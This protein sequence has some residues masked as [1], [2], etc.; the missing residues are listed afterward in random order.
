MEAEGYAVGH[1]VLGAHSVGSVHQRQRL[2]WLADN[3]NQ[4]FDGRK[5]STGITGRLEPET[6]GAINRLADSI[7]SGLE[8]QFWN[9]DN[10][11]EPG[12]KQ[13]NS[14]RSASESCCDSDWM[15]NTESDR[16]RQDGHGDNGS[17]QRE[18]RAKKSKI[19]LMVS[20]EWRDPDWL[21]CRD[22][23]YR[24]IK[25]GIKPLVDG[26]PRGM[27]YCSD[28]GQPINANETAEARVMR[29]RGYGNA[30]VPQVAAEFIMAATSL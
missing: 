26:V 3:Q 12:R 19:G 7:S 23:K 16:F 9:G 11:D 27:G 4:R 21:Y 24:P 15:A 14:T 1:C 30:I 20:G 22:N 5:D 13:E 2:Y 25:P 10:R 6:D 29:L 17:I 8:R 18:D 28:L